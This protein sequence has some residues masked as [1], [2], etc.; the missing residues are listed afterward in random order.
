M[1]THCTN[2]NTVI[3]NSRNTDNKMEFVLT[4]MSS[5]IFVY[6]LRV[7]ARRWSRRRSVGSSGRLSRYA[8]Q[9]GS[10]HWSALEG[11]TTPSLNASPSGYRRLTELL[12]F[13]HLI[14]PNPL[15]T[16]LNSVLLTA[17]LM[18]SSLNPL[19]NI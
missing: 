9:P 15:L 12:L 6:L 4:S 13:H 11:R 8:S 17:T 16:H 18:C 2:K 3:E 7:R 14:K 10:C 1:Q 5:L 19:L